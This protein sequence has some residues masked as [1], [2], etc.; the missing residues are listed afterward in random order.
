METH[1]KPIEEITFSDLRPHYQTGRAVHISGTGR[2]KVF[3]YRHGVMT[4]CGDLE[5]AEWMRQAKQ[6]IERNGEQELYRHLLEWEIG[7]EDSCYLTDEQ[8][9]YQ[10]LDSCISRIFDDQKW[11]DY[12]P[13]NQKY[14]PEV[15]SKADLVWV[16]CTACGKRQQMTRVRYEYLC[17]TFESQ[18]YCTNCCSYATLILTEPPEEGAGN[19]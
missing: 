17:S 5:R 7:Q 9:E 6:V 15:L 3:G 18:L 8:L 13:F 16:K 10:A 1:K 12:I 14:R 2:D 4:D 11:V 19:G